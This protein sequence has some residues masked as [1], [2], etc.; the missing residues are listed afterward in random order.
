ML[1]FGGAD[2]D[3]GGGLTSSSVHGYTWTDIHTL[4][5]QAVADD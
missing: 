1:S 2:R 4:F 3:C 5:L